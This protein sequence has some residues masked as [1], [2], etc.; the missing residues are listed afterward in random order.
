MLSRPLL[1][2]LLTL[3][4]LR[5]VVA[6]ASEVTPE[7]ALVWL[8]GRQAAFGFF[9][10]GPLTSWLIRLGTL[11]AGDSSWGVRW[12]APL[13]MLGAS[14]A[15][16]RLA[17]SAFGDKVA[18]WFLAAW[19]LMPLL[20]MGAVRAWPETVAFFCCLMAAWWTWQALHRA[21]SFRYVNL[22]KT[23]L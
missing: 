15:G 7:E 2:G 3:T 8:G 20:N 9:D 12:F 22:V 14:V 23:M 19:Q 13:L 17:A 6:G 1:I 18:G 16:W 5:W 10:Y 21:C 11:V 4:V